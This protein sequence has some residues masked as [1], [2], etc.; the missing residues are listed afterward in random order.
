MA[1]GLDTQA[2]SAGGERVRVG[3]ERKMEPLR[4][5][6][7]VQGCDTGASRPFKGT[8]PVSLL[9]DVAVLARVAIRTGT[10]VLVRLRVHARP[11]IDTRLV[12]PAV[13]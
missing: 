1:Q 12:A 2:C 9:T 4:R 11:T 7:E 5:D 8:E 13:V 6:G 10:S 3:V